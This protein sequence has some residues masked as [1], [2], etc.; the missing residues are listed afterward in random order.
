MR[1]RPI[2]RLLTS[3]LATLATA[4]F[5]AAVFA[6]DPPPA[7]LVQNGGAEDGSLANWSGFDAVVADNPH[8][9]NHCFIRKGNSTVR[10]NAMIPVAPGKVYTLSGWFRSAGQE[11]S[12]IYFGYAPYDEK[13]RPIGPANVNPLAGTDTTLAQPCAKGD[14]VLK[15]KDGAKWSVLPHGCVA[16]DTDPSGE[17]KDLPNFNLSSFGI[18]KVE[19]KDD[20]WE[21]TLKT[22]CGQDRPAGAPVRMHMSGGTYIYNA[23]GNATVPKD[24][25]QFTGVIKGTAVAGAPSGQWW[26]G[27][28]YVQILVLANFGQKD[29]AVLM[30]DDIT[31]TEADK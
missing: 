11:D 24:W 5:A 23:A 1:N 16:F 22:E 30:A 2:P 27:T 18:V 15:I 29:T 17:Y 20:C 26:P 19:K 31:L 25:K 7:P 28:R 4:S 10:S 14:T 21:V 3:A 12:K 8:T 13:K 6:A 9:G